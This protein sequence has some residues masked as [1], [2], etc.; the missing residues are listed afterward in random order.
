ME[1]AFI[2]EMRNK[3]QAESISHGLR[4]S[5]CAFLKEK[6]KIDSPHLLFSFTLAMCDVHDCMTPGGRVA[7]G[8]WEA[9]LPRIWLFQGAS[10]EL[11]KSRADSNI[12]HS[13]S[14]IVWISA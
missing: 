3:G 7:W 12:F 5:P 13:S 11:D 8:E 6:K 9:L 4:H 14:S 10:P 1:I 2:I